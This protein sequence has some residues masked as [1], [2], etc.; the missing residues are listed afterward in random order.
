MRR[1]ASW[2]RFPGGGAWSRLG[3]IGRGAGA[4]L[5][6]WL[7]LSFQ[8]TDGARPHGTPQ[9]LQNPLLIDAY[10]ETPHGQT[11]WLQAACQPKRASVRGKLARA[12]IAPS[13]CDES[14]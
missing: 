11:R 5:E 10:C 9:S 1:G 8:L 6:R 2:P 13:R 4:F 3:R 7:M 14:L 12:G